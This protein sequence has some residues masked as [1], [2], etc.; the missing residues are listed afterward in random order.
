MPFSSLPGGDRIS[1]VEV[2]LLIMCFGCSETK[3]T[4]LPAPA[5]REKNDTYAYSF[6][7]KLLLFSYTGTRIGNLEHER[8][9]EDSVQ[10]KIT[11]S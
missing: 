8:G 5:F 7:W 9:A 11:Q 6:T 2:K 10:G 4:L 3:Q 1:R